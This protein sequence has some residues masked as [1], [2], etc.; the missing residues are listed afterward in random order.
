MGKC[1]A[2][3][4]KRKE[5]LEVTP[6]EDFF[7]IP[8]QMVPDQSVLITVAGE[9][10]GHLPKWGRIHDSDAEETYCAPCKP[11]SKTSATDSTQTKTVDALNYVLR[12]KCRR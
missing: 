8:T 11:W 4:C 12:Q 6:P 3:N 7:T 9:Q 10:W 2:Q 5:L 1:G